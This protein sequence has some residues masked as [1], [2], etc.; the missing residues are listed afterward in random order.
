MN[1]SIRQLRDFVAVADAASFTRAA[2]ATHIAQPA[3]THQIRR[4][5]SELGVTVFVRGPRGVTLTAEGEELLA[6]ARVILREY[7]A[8][9]ELA[10]R[11]RRRTVGALRVGFLAQ[12]PGELLYEALRA[13]SVGRPATAVALQPFGFD[14]CFMGIT[15]GLTDVG[16]SMGT[17]DE[18]DEVAAKALFEESM[19]VAMAAD[20]PLASR[21]RLH[22]GEVLTQPLFTDVHPPGRYRDYWDAMAYRDGQPPTVINR[23]ATHDEWLEALRLCNGISFCPQSTPAYYPR[24]GLVY[25]PLDGVDPVVHWVMWRKGTANRHADE[26]VATVAAIAAKRRRPHLRAS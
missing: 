2:L 14:D 12:G 17:L 9:R 24:P 19:V 13:F 3:L 10:G 26:F 11:L 1:A 23:A 7:D 22:I 8:L 18:H 25:V 4:L 16:F 21:P 6:Q 20:H 5:E 15:R